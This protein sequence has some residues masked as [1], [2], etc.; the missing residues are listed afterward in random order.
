MTNTERMSRLSAQA[1]STL[2]AMGS[3]K[4]GAVVPLA[5]TVQDSGIRLELAA[6]DIISVHDGL[7]I[8]GSAVACILQSELL[9]RLFG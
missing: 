8:K 1:A 6:L 2:A 7:T 3:S 4:I 9:D 5:D